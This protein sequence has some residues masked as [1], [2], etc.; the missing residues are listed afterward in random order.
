MQRTVWVFGD[1]KIKIYEETENGTLYNP[2]VPLLEYCYLQGFSLN[3]SASF[4][5]RAVTGRGRRKIVMLSDFENIT[6][7]CS[8][9]FFD[10]DTEFN[11]DSIFNPDKQLRILVECSK[12]EY[13][14]IP[15][16]N[17]DIFA[18]SHARATAFSQTGQ[19][20]QNIQATANFEAEL[21][22]DPDAS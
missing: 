11:T 18:L 21:F 15:P 2:E 22:V 7:S 13:S 14:G 12:V 3:A 4:A 5:R 8:H 9:L 10:K 16:F 1:A 19:D 17:N 6:L 20:D